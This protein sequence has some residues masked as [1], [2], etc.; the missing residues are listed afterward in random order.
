[1]AV[2]NLSLGGHWGAHDGTS[3]IENVIA[4]ETGPG[5]IIVV[6]AGNEGSDNIHWNDTLIEGQILTLTSL[7][8][9]DG[10][11]FVDI[12]IPRGDEVSLEL[13]IDNGQIVPIDGLYHP[14]A[15]GGR[16]GGVARVD[17]INNDQ[18]VTLF[19]DA[20]ALGT[21][22]ELRI[23]GVTVTQGHVHAWGGP[24]EANIFP[25]AT[26]EYSIG[27]PAT[28]EQA[29]SVASFVSRNRI[30]SGDPTL[31]GLMVGERSGFSSIGP[32]RY[33]VQKP[34]I[35]APGQF[36]TAA[37]ADN[38]EMA[39]SPKFTSFRDA[40]GELISIQGTSMATPFVA[41]VIALML[42]TEPGLNPGEIK[43]RLRAT[44]TRN[45]TTG[46]IWNNQYGVGRIDVEALLDYG[47]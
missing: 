7:V 8:Q 36:I 27:M 18:N 23:D 44:A 28:E 41:G 11:Q 33:D 13:D 12:W 17:P 46:R 38:S 5:R 34:D 21:H 32:T 40:G 16:V 29:I 6:A 35:S 19:F 25:T 47:N 45:A 1:P 4:A 10:F 2:I 43:Q 31:P 39:N 30:R 42:E 26:N 3:A 14:V 24:R 22:A 37:L 9:D 20:C 15:N